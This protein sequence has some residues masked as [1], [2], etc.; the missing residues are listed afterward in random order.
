MHAREEFCVFLIISCIFC[1]QA[2]QQEAKKKDKWS[3][4]FK[5][6]WHLRPSSSATGAGGEQSVAFSSWCLHCP[7]SLLP[8]SSPGC[9]CICEPG[10]DHKELLCEGMQLLKSDEIQ[11]KRREQVGQQRHPTVP[12]I[13][14]CRA[15]PPSSDP[16]PPHARQRTP[17]GHPPP[18]AHAQTNMCKYTPTNMASFGAVRARRQKIQGSPNAALMAAGFSG[19]P[20]GFVRT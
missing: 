7:P 8:L 4:S 19:V 15:V 17:S 9:S 3:Q 11:L 6:L 13:S 18:P 20:V 10:E 16:S 12:R 1:I 2:P 14:G 5:V